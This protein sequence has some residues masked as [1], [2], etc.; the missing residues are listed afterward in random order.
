MKRNNIILNSGLFFTCFALGAIFQGNAEIPDLLPL[1]SK[2]EW[3]D[4]TT[5][6]SPE[7]SIGYASPSGKKMGEHFARTLRAGTGWSVPEVSWE[8]AG[9]RLKVHRFSSNPQE[10]RLTVGDKCIELEACSEKA[11]ASGLQTLLQMMPTDIYAKGEKNG[12]ELQQGVITDSPAIGHRGI[13]VDV[14]R[15]FQDKDTILKLLDGLAACKINSFQW[16]LTDDQGWRFPSKGYPKLT[17]KNPAYS[18]EDIKEIVERAENLGIQIIPEIDMPGHCGAVASAYPELC[19]KREDGTVA[20]VL[21]VGKPEVLQFV[22]TVIG[23][24]SAIIPGKYFHIGADEVGK[25]PW[26]GSAECQELMKK[27]NL[28]DLNELQAWFVKKVADVVRKNNRQPL[29][30]DEALEGGLGEFKDIGILSWR[31]PDIGVKALKEGHPVIWTT[32]DR[33][34]F[35]KV[36]SRSKDQPTG[37][38]DNN[39]LPLHMTYSYCPLSPVLADQEKSLVIGSQAGLWSEMIKGPD[40]M[41]ILVFP[42]ICAL[43]EAMWTSP[44]KKDWDGFLKRQ[45]TMNE[46]LKAMEIPFFWE[47]KTLPVTLGSWTP[48]EVKEPMSTL[49]FPLNAEGMNLPGYC[50]VDVDYTSGKGTVEV[51]KVELFD[52]EGNIVSQD[53]HSYIST[54]YK[55]GTAK[56]YCLHIP[57]AGKYKVKVTLSP[58]GEG[59]C[60]GKVHMIKPLPAGEYHPLSDLNKPEYRKS[61]K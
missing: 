24:L 4:Q 37:Y 45:R 15:H 27:E 29:A 36:N 7:V 47:E 43:G 48:E 42:R 11:L 25:S 2:M 50:E 46:R 16:H 35:D 52:A 31:S 56:Q 39:V 6:I 60:N 28:K 54:F 53:E 18:L 57:K 41:F 33:I 12:I 40:H 3:K 38:G 26:K 8:K 58:M 23:E 22:E 14:S 20:N 34:Y 32:G 19:A 30:W 1:P 44:E 51:H 21:N 17:E 59:G 49:I 13:S 55:G 9:I 10:Y 5:F 61:T